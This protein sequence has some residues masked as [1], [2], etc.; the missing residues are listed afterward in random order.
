[1][2]FNTLVL[3]TTGG[4]SLKNSLSLQGCSG[5]IGYGFISTFKHVANCFGEKGGSRSVLPYL[6]CTLANLNSSIS[7]PLWNYSSPTSG[8]VLPFLYAI[9]SLTV[10]LSKLGASG[11]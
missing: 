2:A 5:S 4:L 3:P 8:G 10:V 1:M 9:P 7:S 11:G 6:C